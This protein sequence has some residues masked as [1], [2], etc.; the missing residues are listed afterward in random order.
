MNEFDVISTYFKSLSSAKSHVIFGIG[1][2]AACVRVPPQHDLLISTDTLVSGVHFLSHWD[3]YDIACKAVMVNVSDMAAM[4]ATPLW[5]T[6]ALTM[7]TC[8]ESWL[9]RFSEGLRDSL[10]PYQL[11][12]IGGDT[13]KGPLSIT[14]TIHGTVPEGRAVRRS[15]AKPNDVIYVSGTL[16]AAALAVAF[17]SRDDTDKNDYALS[18]NALL[19]P[20]PRVDLAPLLQTYAS[21]AIDISDGLLAD[22]QHICVASGVGARLSWDSIPVNALVTKYFGSNAI[23]FALRGGDD[24]QLCFTVDPHRELTFLASLKECG[25]SCHRI[26]EIE[27]KPGIRAV[28]ANGNT[29]SLTISGYSHF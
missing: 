26:G 10:N 15:G 13:T 29:L 25:L 22:L 2:D 27:A 18:M 28:D 24:Y 7:P 4:G 12:L 17:L 20:I 23:D 21:A 19:H 8:D 11:A 14:I 1:D 6:L 3:P 9:Q 16:G 5:I